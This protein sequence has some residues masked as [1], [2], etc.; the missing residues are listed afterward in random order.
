[1]TATSIAAVSSMAD[2]MADSMANPM[3]N[4]M[5]GPIA[6]PIVHTVVDA[7]DEIPE[8][9]T[10]RV[11]PVAGEPRPFRPAQIGMVGA[12]GIGEAAISI[13][14]PPS[15]TAY[16]E[17]TIRRSGA[18]TTALTGLRAGDQLWV[19]GPFGVPWDLDHDGDVVIAAGGIGL[20]P[21][22][23]AVYHLLKHRWRY[24]R[25][26]LVV[27]AR[28]PDDLLYRSEFDRWRAAGVEIFPTIDRTMP[29]WDGRVGLVPEVVAEVLAEASLDTR[30][31]HALIC[32]PDIMMRLTADALVANGTAP[33]RIQLTLE[34]NMQCGIGR[35]GHCQ[36][37]GLIVCRDG[38][39]VRYPRVA[40]A[41]RIPE[42]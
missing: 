12:F 14:S 40:A 1:M 16:H 25:I 29:N 28:R 9:V 39:V 3:A 36:L 41:M 20:A 2:P 8:V 38:P 21:L 7:I 32:G 27:G 35:C 30:R 4:P 19:R 6:E 31:L 23:S 22:R 10:L 24:G 13:S 17:Y 5:A 37:G 15:Q 42:W 18:I 33:E 26:A 34:R 11:V